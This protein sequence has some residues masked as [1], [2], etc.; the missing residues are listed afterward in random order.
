MTIL[1]TAV[2]LIV[3]LMALPDFCR[4]IHRPGLTYPLYIVAGIAAGAFMGTE[5]R[6]VWRE[7]GQFGFILL[8]FSVGLEIELPEKRETLVALRRGLLWLAW[9]LPFLVGMAHLA[10]IPWTEG[11]VAAV[12]LA[13]TSVGMA[14]HLWSRYSFPE[15][16]SRKVFLE[17]IVAVEVLSIL[18]LAAVGPVLQGAVWW[19]VL[20]QFGG[21]VVAA[22]VAAFVA[23][24]GAPRIVGLLTRGLHLQ[25]HFLVLLLFGVAAVGERLGLSAPKTAFVLGMFISRA[26]TEEAALNERLE[27]LR[28]R[29]F[30]P[31]FFFGLGTLVELRLLLSSVVPIAIGA[32]V[33]LF[34]ARKIAYR[35][36]FSRMLGTRP[37]AHVIA[38]PMLTIAAVAVE[39]FARAGASE[40]VI[41]WTLAAGLCLTLIASFFRVGPGQTRVSEIELEMAAPEAWEQAEVAPRQLPASEVR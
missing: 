8:L 3:L 38:A 10:G 33:L 5:V 12:A 21:L 34:G 9:Q 31:V 32:G 37:D 1:E 24:H 41:T 25:V 36:F 28:D 39:V 30:V 4:R 11:V 27:P 18:L 20:L 19:R 23:V 16:P 6:H 2:F 35:L 7:I 22:I 29:M 14:F 15:G 26:T 17:W 40:R 13:S